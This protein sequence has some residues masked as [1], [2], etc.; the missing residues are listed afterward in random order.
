[1]DSRELGGPCL[2]GC[3]RRSDKKPV[4]TRRPR[5]ICDRCFDRLAEWLR[6][7]P[8]LWNSLGTLVARGSL[9]Q[10]EHS[11][12]KMT[13]QAHAP[14]PIRPEAVSLL[15]KRGDESVVY[16]LNRW[17]L[18]LRALGRL[19]RHPS[20][21]HPDTA[22]LLLHL[23]FLASIPQVRS[24]WLE[25]R[26]MHRQL[27]YALGEQ[28]PAA[29]GVCGAQVDDE[30]CG[31]P[32]MPLQYS[33]GVRCQWCGDEW[34]EGDLRGLGNLLRQRWVTMQ[35]AAYLSSRPEATLRDWQAEMLL[36]SI[37]DVGSRQIL[38]D[39]LALAPL[40]ESR[41]TRRRRRLA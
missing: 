30:A 11:G 4:L 33:V 41:R 16:R 34:T 3:T 26:T 17:H 25:T 1:M 28:P 24:L 32:L 6:D 9:G 39:A 14:M 5:L 20:W 12:G 13:K 29:V 15:D 35:V 40:A 36:P 19:T 27:R 21:E 22:G 23:E 10:Q 37:C 8:T 18:W 7:I 38:V 31:G 2:N